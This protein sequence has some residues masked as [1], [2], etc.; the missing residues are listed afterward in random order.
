MKPKFLLFFLLYISTIKVLLADE[1]PC[2]GKFEVKSKNLKFIAVV[3]RINE[4]SLKEPWDSRWTLTV[5]ENI[6]HIK[7]M[8]WSTMYD[9]SGYPE[10]ALS[11]DGKYFVYI[12]SWYSEKKPLAQIYKSGKHVN[13]SSL[14]GEK[15]HIPSN[16]IMKSASH[17]LW[18]DMT[19]IKGFKK[20]KGHLVYLLTTLDKQ[21]HIINLENGSIETIE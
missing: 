4:D 19:G 3:Q 6:N 14:T 15:F 2:W 12:E 10:G 9:Y 17:K 5:Y 16:K 21:T 1:P 20:S 18:L 7:K 11:D 13:S 8:I